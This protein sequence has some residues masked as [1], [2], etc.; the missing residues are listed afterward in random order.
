MTAR[1]TAIVTGANHGIGAATARALARRGCAVLCTF[2]R[3]QD[4]DDPGTPQEYRDKRAQDAAAVVADVRIEGGTAVAM[5]ADLSGPDTPCSSTPQRSSSAPPASWSTL[6]GRHLRRH[7]CRPARQ[8]T[9]AGHGGN[10]DPPIHR[11]RDGRGDRGAAPHRRFALP[12]GVAVLRPGSERA[13]PRRRGQVHAWL[14]NDAAPQTLDAIL[15]LFPRRCW[16][17]TAT[18]GSRST[19]LWTSG[20]PPTSQ[21]SNGTRKV[22]S[23]LHESW[24]Q[25]SA[26]RSNPAPV[27]RYGKPTPSPLV[28]RLSRGPALL[29]AVSSLSPR[30]VSGGRQVRDLWFPSDMDRRISDRADHGSRRTAPPRRGRS[31]E[32]PRW[33]P[34]EQRA[35]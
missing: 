12:A 8:D 27:R 18:S 14:L 1:H 31:P 23:R 3:L 21:P 29:A 34:G 11:R 25:E 15:G 33:L 24:S 17:P 10:L 4:R 26:V 28:P 9:P 6:A 30:S 2:L 32:W 22:R 16:P 13:A 35:A 20:T 5:E 7:H 19:P